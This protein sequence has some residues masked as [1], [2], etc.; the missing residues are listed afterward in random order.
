MGAESVKTEQGGGGGASIPLRHQSRIMDAQSRMHHLY[1]SFDAQS[2]MNLP[3]IYS[4]ATVNYDESLEGLHSS[5]MKVPGQYPVTS[6]HP[7]LP[8][9][10]VFFSLSLSLPLSLSLSLFHTHTHTHK[11]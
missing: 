4:Q 5:T 6:L 10:Q 3:P 1:A 7:P 8:Q 9:E 2:R 11:S